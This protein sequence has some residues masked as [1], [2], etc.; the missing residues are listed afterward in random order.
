MRTYMVNLN[1]ITYQKLIF[2]TKVRVHMSE[3]MYSTQD[4]GPP[5]VPVC[6]CKDH[7]FFS[8]NIKIERIQYAT[9]NNIPPMVVSI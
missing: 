3:I 4:H 8:C 9:S 1:A 2:D 6:Y 5:R 7:N